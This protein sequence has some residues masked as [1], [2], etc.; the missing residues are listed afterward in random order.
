MHSREQDQFLRSPSPLPPF[1]PVRKKPIEIV[2]PFLPSLPNP[3]T[4]VSSPAY[5]HIASLS[6]SLSPSSFS[7]SSLAFTS[8]HATKFILS[9]QGR[10]IDISRF[11][12]RARNP[13]NE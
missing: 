7:S 9:R 13:I 11:S 8:R 1:N 12:A 3:L 6:L 4:L 2:E 10:R 5:R